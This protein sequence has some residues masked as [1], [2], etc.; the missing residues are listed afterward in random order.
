MW[1]LGINTGHNGAAALYKD[2]ELIFY[3]EEDRLS[4]LKYD[5]N[6]FLGIEKAFEYTDHIDFIILCGTRNAFGKVPWTGEDAYSCLVR[7]KQPGHKVETVL[8]GDDH[9]LTHAV[10]A[11][12]NSGFDDA[13][14]IVIDGAGSGINIPD[15]EQIKHETWEVES[16]WTLAYPAEIKR[17]LVNYGTNLVDSFELLDND[18][19]V[20]VSDGHGI[21]KSYEAVTQYL[22]FHAIEAG[23]TMG[24]APYGKPNDNIK[25]HDG[26]F[27][28]RSLIKPKFPAGNVIR[29]DLNPE[30]KE[31]EGD[32]AWHTDPDLIDDF[33]KD[34][35][36][37]VQK[38]AEERV[39]ALIRKT[40]ELTGKKKIVMAGGFVLNCVANYEFLKEFPDV[41]FY[42]EPVSHDGGNVMGVCQYVY[43]SITK[44]VVKT[45]LTS[46]YLGF[47][48]SAEYATA[49]FAGFESFDITAAEV[50]Q[51]IADQNIVCL[52][53]GR[54][55]AGP[56]ALGN[57]S[58]L[59]DPTV[60]NGKDIVNEVKHREWF[61]P[62]AGSVMAEHAAEWFDFR[63]RTD[64]P[65][66]MY[67]VNVLEDKQALIPAITHV[68][69]TCR[70]QTVT[71]EQNPHYYELISEFKKLKGVPILFNTSF[72]LAGDPLVETVKEA[73]T[74]MERSEMKYLW[75]PDI[76][77]L[78]TKN[79]FKEV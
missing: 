39:I 57:R 76:G 21:T 5:G 74:T 22:G 23:K 42:H 14:A 25:I 38:S 17:H 47:D 43:R 8:L 35:A 20:E 69:G 67:A 62:F 72:N 2:S 49:D 31:H 24:I 51:L 79:N 64:S 66:M 40:I 45:P 44:D 7:K 58:I 9:H 32:V 27:N 36:Y 54:S 48:H 65:F 61:R 75:L 33:R 4:R 13:A 70:I 15:L 12:Y 1:L 16:V 52:Y 55:E 37:A 59:F 10:T 63:S 34:L 50:A 41:E 71:S 29:C 60:V 77:K 26:R 46:L 28:N 19:Q 73:L 53:Q 30:L 78:L 68:D 3:I 6:P 56:R 11:F 18:C